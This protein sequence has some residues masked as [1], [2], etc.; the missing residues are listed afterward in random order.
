MRT[1]L[2]VLLSFL[3]SAA[4]SQTIG[5]WTSQLK[6]PFYAA[7]VNDSGHLFGQWC[8][9][10]SASC[11]Y[12]VA[13]ST[14][15]DEGESYPILVNSDVSSLSTTLVCRG[16]LS[17]GKFRYALGNFDDIDGIVRKAKRIGIAL[18]LEGDK[19]RVIRFSL[20]GAAA[21]LILMRGAVEKAVEGPSSKSTR[22]QRL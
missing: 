4:S 2:A 5:E 6:L 3:S 22:D 14:R 12:M 15:C 1:A 9:V 18:P 16:R 19:F 21:S 20:D 11:M 8:D 17:S 10:D 7:T 13:L